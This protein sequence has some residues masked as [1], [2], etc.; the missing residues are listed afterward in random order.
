MINFEHDDLDWVFGELLELFN[1]AVLYWRYPHEMDP[2][3]FHEA[4]S[5]LNAQPFKVRNDCYQAL[6]AIWRN[7]TYVGRV[8]E[9]SKRYE[10]ALP[11]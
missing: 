6:M 4:W 1:R 3:L 8:V 11:H 10:N 7:R 2:N 5:I 9:K